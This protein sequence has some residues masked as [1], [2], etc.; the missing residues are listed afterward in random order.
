MLRFAVSY[1]GPI[2]LRYPRGS[3]P[4]IDWGVPESPIEL[5]KA[6]V[7]RE[8][9]DVAVF[10]IGSM[11]ATAFAAVKQLEQEGIHAALINAR[12]AKPLDR[13]TILRF[14][15]RVPRFVLVE[16]NAICGGFGSAVLELL[17]HEGVTGVRVKH[18][19]VPDEFIEHGS[20]D[21]LRRLVGLSTEH[22]VEA[23]RALCG[24]PRR[25]PV[26]LTD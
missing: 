26:V 21:I 15:H 22:I 16:E 10:A 20:V 18:L 2:A 23:A 8:G 1:N 4:A 12:F 25:A 19:A 13:E 9:D 11:V 7:L 3:V 5:G 6:E 17:A 24:V 14:A